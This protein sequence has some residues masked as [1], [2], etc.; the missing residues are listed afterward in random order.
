[1]QRSSSPETAAR[2]APNPHWLKRVWPAGVRADWRVAE[3]GCGWSSAL[4]WT[5]SAAVAAWRLH[6]GASPLFRAETAP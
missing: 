6:A 2:L 4:F 5:E 3:C 1:M